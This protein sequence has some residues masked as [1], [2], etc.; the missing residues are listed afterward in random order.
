MGA[1][2]FV[3][4]GWFGLHYSVGHI[5]FGSM[6]LLPFIFLAARNILNSRYQLGVLA[7]LALFL[8]DGG[9]YTFIFSCYLFVS[10]V[11]FTF[12]FKRKWLV[13]KAYGL[14]KG[15]K[16]L[17]IT[18]AAAVLTAVPKLVPVLMLHKD[19]VPVKESTAVKLSSLPSIFLDIFQDGDFPYGFHEVG[20]YIG[21][22][23]LALIIGAL[24]RKHYVRNNYIL[25]S[26]GFLWLWIALGWGAWFNPW[27]ILQNIPFF[28]HAHIQ[29]RL[30]ILV[31]L[32]IVILIV[33]AIDAFNP[34]RLI[35][36]ALIGVLCLES[37]FV[38]NWPVSDLY[39]R[40]ASGEQ[41]RE[42]SGGGR[43][44]ATAQHPYRSKMASH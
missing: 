32:A 3:G 44:Q 34:H 18:T 13:E 39:R 23:S 33:R 2:L 14:F 24:F 4:S 16:F 10:I 19:R 26:F 17:F 11:F 35:R 20:C 29:S 41:A 40:V 12:V 7:V 15:W 27:S 9:I 1:Q 22:L 8:L 30:L 6:Q 36:I 42:A 21:V 37:A 43:T 25:F 31:Y 28:Q 38:R 5:T